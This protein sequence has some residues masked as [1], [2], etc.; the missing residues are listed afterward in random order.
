GGTIQFR[1]YLII[2]VAIAASS[3]GKSVYSVVYLSVGDR[4]SS[5][6]NPGN[7]CVYQSHEILE[8]PQTQTSPANYFMLRTTKLRR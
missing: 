4:T 6:G 1:L 7:S 8:L 2:A 3:R 5:N